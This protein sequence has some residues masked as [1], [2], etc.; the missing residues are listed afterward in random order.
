MEHILVEPGCHAINQH[1]TCLADTAANADMAGEHEEKYCSCND[2][3]ANR[4]DGK[5]FY[6]V[7][8]FHFDNL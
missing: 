4:D 6:G 2:H 3:I 7:T 5:F 8:Q 1:L